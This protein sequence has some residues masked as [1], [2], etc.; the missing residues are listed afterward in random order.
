[1]GL[2]SCTD[3]SCVSGCDFKKFEI[4]KSQIE[5][6]SEKWENLKN[7]FEKIEKYEKYEK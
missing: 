1:M 3:C 4:L 5:K 6:R 2:W 7:K